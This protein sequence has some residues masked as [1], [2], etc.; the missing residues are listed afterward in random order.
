MKVIQ[1][2][3]K[4]KNPPNNIANAAIYC[5]EPEVLNWI[6]LNENIQDFSTEVIPKFLG[7]VATWR[8]KRIHRDIG[9]I[10][11]L[12]IAQKDHIQK[13]NWIPDK[14]WETFFKKHKIHQIMKDLK[15]YKQ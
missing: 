11:N 9:T 13:I 4:S 6:N 5:L 8:N 14:Y 1:R 12:K 15:I 7:R 3:E 10:E 2:H